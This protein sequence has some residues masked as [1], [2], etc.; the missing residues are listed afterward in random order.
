MCEV[1]A[2]VRVNVRPVCMRVP[3]CVRA[4]VC[5]CGVV[6]AMHMWCMLCMHVYMCMCLCVFV[7][8]FV[9]NRWCVWRLMHPWVCVCVLC[10][11]VCIYVVECGWCGI[12]DAYVV[13]VVNACIY[14]R[15]SVCVCVYVC[16]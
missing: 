1:Y 8:M 5:V 4:F 16:M 11:H 12:C 6:F 10:V 7:Y 15:V 2:C 14:V 13:Y 3:A 9:S